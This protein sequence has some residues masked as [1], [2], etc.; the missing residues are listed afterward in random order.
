[1]YLS[2]LKKGGHLLLCIPHYK[3]PLTTLVRKRAPIEK[4]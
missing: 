1:M 2:T 3:L 4:A